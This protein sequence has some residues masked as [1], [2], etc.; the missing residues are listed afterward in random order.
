MQDKQK[1]TLYLPPDLH[2]Q[3][4]IRSAVELE[5]MSTIAERA[6]DFYLT[7]SE[8]VDEVEAAHG[9]THRVYSC[10]ECAS[11]L[12][13]REGEMA[14]LSGQVGVLLEDSSVERI[15]GSPDQRGEGE[16]VP[17]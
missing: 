12:V 1:V 16:L 6:I 3:L 10:P 15:S 13:L 14:S 4:K 5:P 17:C 7:H 9:Q 2:R 8:V 11:S